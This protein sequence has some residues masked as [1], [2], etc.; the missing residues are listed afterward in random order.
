MQENPFYFGIG[1]KFICLTWFP[2]LSTLHTLPS[3]GKSGVQGMDFIHWTFKSIT[4]STGY[5]QV[6]YT[7]NYH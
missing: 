6:T 3:N 5:L 1:Q 7:H 4:G 2:T